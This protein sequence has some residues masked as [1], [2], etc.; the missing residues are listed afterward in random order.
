MKVKLGRE[1]L[2]NDFQ[3]LSGNEH[4]SEDLR[5][6]HDEPQPR[7][8]W[9]WSGNQQETELLTSDLKHT[10]K[11]HVVVKRVIDVELFPIRKWRHAGMMQRVQQTQA[12]IEELEDRIKYDSDEQGLRLVSYDKQLHSDLYELQQKLRNFT[13]YGQWLEEDMPAYTDV[14]LERLERSLNFSFSIRVG[15]DFLWSRGVLT[16]C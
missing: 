12:K 7:Y 11:R 1:L 13:R 2:V 15:H 10:V 4:V 3:L 14:V 8:Q 16:I 9:F 6:L 5:K